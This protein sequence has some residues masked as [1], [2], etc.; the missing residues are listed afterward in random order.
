MVKVTGGELGIEPKWEPNEPEAE[1]EWVL[2]GG[3]TETL[4]GGLSLPKRN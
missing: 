1:L 4:R 2:G 3:L